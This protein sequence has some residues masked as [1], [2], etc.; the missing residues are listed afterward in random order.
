[1]AEC[2][3]GFDASKV[4]LAHLVN[5]LDA[6]GFTPQDTLF[7]TDHLQRF[8]AAEIPQSECRKRLA[9]ALAVEAALF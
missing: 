7:I 6:A 2:L 8:G 4:A 5:H 1:M 9:A 3:D